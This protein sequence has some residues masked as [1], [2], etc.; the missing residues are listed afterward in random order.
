MIKTTDTMFLGYRILLDY[1]VI[2]KPKWWDIPRR[3]GLRKPE[4]Y[5]TTPKGSVILSKENRF[6]TVRVDDYHDLLNSPDFPRPPARDSLAPSGSIGAGAMGID[7][8]RNVQ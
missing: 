4:V 6:M 1:G 8:I 3:L 7:T 5:H 2:I